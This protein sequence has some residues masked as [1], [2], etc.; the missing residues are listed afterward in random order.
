MIRN[1]VQHSENLRNSLVLNYESP[2]LTAELQGRFSWV[3]ISTNGIRN[4]RKIEW[5]W[6]R[7][8]SR[9]AAIPAKAGFVLDSRREAEL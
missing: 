1:A 2:A 5:T 7:R 8:C 4:I 3:K 9:S 6:A